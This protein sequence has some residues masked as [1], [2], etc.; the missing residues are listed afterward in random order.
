MAS[1]NKLDIIPKNE[2]IIQFLAENSHYREKLR[3][4]PTKTASGV[5]VIAIMP[6]PYNCPHGR[7]IYCPGG[8]EYNTPL[9]YIG[10]EPVTKLAQ[11]FEFDPHKQIQSKILQLKNRGHNITKVELVIVGGTFPFMPIEYQKTFVKSCFDS[12]N[13]KESDSLEEALKMNEKAELRC[14]GFTIETKPDYCKQNHVD[15]MLELGVTRVEIGVQTLQNTIY[16]KVNRGHDLKD[17]T[18]AFKIARDSGYKIVAH[19]M[20]GLPGSSPKKDIK[21][22]KILLE[23]PRFKPDMLK[24]YPTLVLKNTGLYK[25]Y[26]EKKYIPYS[27]EDLINI[28]IE[29]KKIVPKWIRIMRVQR[30]IEDKDIVAGPKNGNLRQ[31]ILE[32]MNLLGI[33][34]KCIRCREGGLQSRL[35]DDNN[36]IMNRIDYDAS[37]GKEIFL[38]MESKDSESMLGFLRMRNTFSAGRKELKDVNQSIKNAV[39]IRELH[40]YGKL[41]DIG[42][43]KNH[44]SFQHRGLGKKL[45][46]EAERIAREELN[47]KKI[48]VISAI[49]TREYYK[50]MGYFIN[51]PYVSKLV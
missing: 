29:V 40:V 6:K 11:I 20:P 24:I 21:D 17:V 39:V 35:I 18:K 12:L 38:S 15:T 36:I 48:S 51:G 43:K 3:V 2:H 23:E 27:D 42:N 31:I 5:A 13:L 32:K 30:E 8:I 14:V 22:F 45:M 37:N 26:N 34:C 16:K 28:L 50:K 44:E 9:S 47:V 33:K 25:L 46:K 41:L 4:R 10:S 1:K 49:G 19:M 7:C